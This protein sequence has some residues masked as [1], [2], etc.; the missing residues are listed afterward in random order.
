MGRTVFGG[1]GRDHGGVVAKILTVRTAE[2]GIDFFCGGGRGRSGA[3]I[4]FR[5]LLVIFRTEL[6][7]DLPFHAFSGLVCAPR[8]LLEG[9]VEGEIVTNGVL[10]KLA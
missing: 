9:F 7:S 1:E 8:Y 6:R 2:V 5:L 4:A 10:G 3:A